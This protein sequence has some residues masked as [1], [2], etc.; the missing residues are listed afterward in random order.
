M[1]K[2]SNFQSMYAGLQAYWLRMFLICYL[3]QFLLDYYHRLNYVPEFWQPARFHY[4]T[5]IDYDIHDPF[6]DAFN[7]KLV[8]SF[9][10]KSGFA[11]G[12]PSGK[13]EFIVV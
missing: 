12:H 7:R 2:G 5:G 8:A 10:G 13:D 1:E 3:S 4:P 9:H 11:A 6:T